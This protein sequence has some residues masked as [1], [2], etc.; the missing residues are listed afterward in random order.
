M[1]HSSGSEGNTRHHYVP[2]PC[3]TSKLLKRLKR[4]YNEPLRP[5]RVAF[6]KPTSL[7]FQSKPSHP[8]ILQLPYIYKHSSNSYINNSKSIS[9]QHLLF[10]QHKF[11]LPRICA[12]TASTNTSFLPLSLS[13]CLLHPERCYS[14][15]YIQTKEKGSRERLHLPILHVTIAHGGKS[16]AVTPLLSSLFQAARHTQNRK[17]TAPL[18]LQSMHKEHILHSVSLPVAVSVHRA[19]NP[20][21]G[22][23]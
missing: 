1:K 10:E 7:E 21:K 9:P 5:Y 16:A 23:F 4:Q 15:T 12:C 13:E 18:K 2:L 17:I 19:S 11:T 6:R 22:R 14:S 3:Q 8:S 20:D